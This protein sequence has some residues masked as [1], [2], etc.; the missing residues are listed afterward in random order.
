MTSGSRRQSGP[1]YLESDALMDLVSSLWPPYDVVIVDAAPLNAGSDA[2]A[3][4][5]LAG[6][7]L[8]VVRLGT[9]DRRLAASKL[10]SLDSFPV[11][12]LGTV[13]NDVHSEQREY[14]L[15]LYPERGASPHR[16]R[17]KR[18]LQILGVN[19]S[20]SRRAGTP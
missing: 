10:E 9:T 8:F 20:G 11:R 7:M 6:N 14:T 15:H 2:F 19:A 1:E 5:T 3:L 18:P 4:A 13:L 16:D 12:L 17:D